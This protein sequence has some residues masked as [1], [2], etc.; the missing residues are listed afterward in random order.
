LI[1]KFGEASEKE[2]TTLTL[3]LLMLVLLEKNRG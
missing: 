3:S 1:E 2:E